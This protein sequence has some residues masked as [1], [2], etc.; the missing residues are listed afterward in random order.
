MEILVFIG[1]FLLCVLGALQEI[2]IS[3]L[4]KKLSS[5]EAA[6]AQYSDEPDFE[7]IYKKGLAGIMAYSL[8]EAEGSDEL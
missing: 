5:L 2:K 1:M 8:K 3:E 4:E 7:E 6:K